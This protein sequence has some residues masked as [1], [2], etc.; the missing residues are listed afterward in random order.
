M[1]DADPFSLDGKVALVTG[2]GR[3]RGAC[4]VLD[5]LVARTRL[6]RLGAPLDISNVKGF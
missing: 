6:R 2:G 5:Q 4:R 1:A 3:G